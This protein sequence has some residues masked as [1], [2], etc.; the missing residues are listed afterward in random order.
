MKDPFF[1]FRYYVWL[2]HH[3]IANSYRCALSFISEPEILTPTGRQYNQISELYSML[4]LHSTYNTLPCLSD[5]TTFSCDKAMYRRR[6]IPRSLFL[7]KLVSTTTFKFITPAHFETHE[8][9]NIFTRNGES[10]TNLEWTRGG[11]TAILCQRSR[12][13]YC[14]KLITW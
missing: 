14:R 11:T 1:K 3:S 10:I 4:G 13:S 2:I 7:G 8:G 12:L 9:K 6:P 5:G